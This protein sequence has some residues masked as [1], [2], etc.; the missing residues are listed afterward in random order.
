MI[1]VDGPK[2]AKLY[3]TREILMLVPIPSRSTSAEAGGATLE[4]AI[5]LQQ[6]SSLKTINTSIYS[7]TNLQVALVDAVSH[8]STDMEEGDD[9]LAI[10]KLY[11]IL[12]ILWQNGMSF[13]DIL[14]A[15]QQVADLYFVLPSK[16]QVRLYKFLVTGWAYHARSRCSFLDLLCCAQD[17]G[18]LIF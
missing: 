16:S 7:G 3:E 10:E 18:L 12:G 15:V 6:L 14:H 9:L 2:G 1:P 13:E 8:V 4:E 5:S 11:E 17:A